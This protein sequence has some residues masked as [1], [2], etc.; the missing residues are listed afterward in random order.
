[1]R[2]LA[3]QARRNLC[4]LRILFREYR[5]GAESPRRDSFR[6]LSENRD[7]TWQTPRKG[8]DYGWPHRW[9]DTVQKL[10]PDAIPLKAEPVVL[11]AAIEGALKTYSPA[12]AASCRRGIG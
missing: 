1:M 11:I 4:H 12:H 9:Q 5:D 2:L 6:S 7:G 8:A 3:T 10:L